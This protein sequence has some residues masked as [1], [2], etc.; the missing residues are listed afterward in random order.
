MATLTRRW[1]K[2]F[3]TVVN[4]V[5]LM[6]G[7]LLIYTVVTKILLPPAED[8]LLAGNI[9]RVRAGDTLP[10]LPDFSWNDSEYTLLLALSPRCRYCSESMPFYRRLVS[11]VHAGNIPLRVAAL[12]ASSIP[13]QAADTYLK[14]SALEVDRVLIA[15]LDL[16]GIGGTPTL[17]LADRSG[18]VMNVWSGKTKNEE[19]EE[20]RS[21]LMALKGAECCR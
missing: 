19:E 14:D 16:L 17:V 1:R 21:Q 9:T 15:S 18:K 20:L 5:V 12:F 3:E 13:P 2:K 10:A 8:E 7:V 11:S 6:A 4:V